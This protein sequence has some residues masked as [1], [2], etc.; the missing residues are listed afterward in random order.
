MGWGARHAGWLGMT[1]ACAYNE[2]MHGSTSYLPY[3]PL[4][5]SS[6][7]S[8]PIHTIIILIII[9]I[10][11]WDERKCGP[12]IRSGNTSSSLLGRITRQIMSVITGRH[13][14]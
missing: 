3:L 14:T 4:G 5:G 11:K 13:V 1:P 12:G 9:I 2:V 10:M 8:Y 7:P 6:S